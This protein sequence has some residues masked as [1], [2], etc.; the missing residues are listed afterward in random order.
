MYLKEDSPETKDEVKPLTAAY[1]I[2]QNGP[3]N[4]SCLPRRPGVL[5]VSR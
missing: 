1:T 5:P 4:E 2:P 3:R